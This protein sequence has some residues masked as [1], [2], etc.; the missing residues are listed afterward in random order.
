MANGEVAALAGLLPGELR[1]TLPVAD[2]D[3]RR[4]GSV[5]AVLSFDG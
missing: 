2:G 1:P 5:R 4:L 3:R